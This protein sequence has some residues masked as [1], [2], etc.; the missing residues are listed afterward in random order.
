[1]REKVLDFAGR[2]GANELMITSQ[3]FDPAARRESYRLLAGA[4]R[5]R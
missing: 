4:L 2:T 1:V 5:R 3:I